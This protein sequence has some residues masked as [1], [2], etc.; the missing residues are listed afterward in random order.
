MQNVIATCLVTYNAPVP[1]YRLNSELPEAAVCDAVFN[2]H[3]RRHP[4]HVQRPRVA[5]ENGVRY[6]RRLQRDDYCG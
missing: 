4:R 3:I 1:L 5:L 6:I 2:P